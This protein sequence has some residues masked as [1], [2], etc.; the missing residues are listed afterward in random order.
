M[1]DEEVAFAAMESRDPRFD[2]WFFVAVTTTRIYCRPSCPAVMPKRENVR[3]FPS[4]SAA[5]ANGFRACRRCRP[6]AAPGSPEWDLRTDLAA[7]AMRLIADGVVDREGVAGLA[8]RL[9]YSVRQVHRQLVAEVGAGAQALARAQRARTARLLLESGGLPVSD[10]A[11]AAGFASIRQF[12]ET[13]RQAYG[14]T[15]SRLRGPGTARLGVVEVR[16]A[17]R[18][19][20]DVPGML[21][22]L[23]E[24]AIPGIEEYAPGV[25]TR[26]L[27][28]PHA[29]GVV[30]LRHVP[31]ADHVAC[32]LWLDDLRDLAAAVRRCRRM[33]DLDAD[34]QAV[35]AFLAGDPLLGPRVA[36]RPGVRVPG[37]V[38]PEEL[39]VRT[40]LGGRVAGLAERYGRPLPNPVGGVT[41]T[42]PG[43]AALGTAEPLIRALAGGRLRLDS[44]ADPQEA[45]KVLAD[46]PGV[47]EREVAIIRMRALGD[48]DV[49]V[50]GLG[51]PD[52]V[53]ARWRPWRS[54]AA[55]HLPMPA[56]R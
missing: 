18:P 16:L 23:G 8:G 6:D 44:G 19:P 39:A 33:L 24:Q 47:G 41:R 30:S 5:Q 15:P 40:V 45:R 22:A 17:F 11:F 14:T 42:F 28:L 29:A 10:V 50:P 54:Y 27:V 48:P 35:D 36:A 52:E 43:V 13:I 20:M 56:A 31:G 7:R 49:L 9:G 38:D 32:A 46:L 12:N 1:I 53:W 25:Y 51:V 3:L 2:G 37:H 55:Q 4:A 26:S 21:A 34:Q